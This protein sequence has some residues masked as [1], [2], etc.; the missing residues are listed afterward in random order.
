MEVE[1]Y[2]VL[3]CAIE[4]GSLSAAAE[5]LH[6]TTSGISRMMAALE[7]EIGFPLLLRRHEGVSPTAECLA[8]LP[9]IR[10]FLFHAEACRMQAKRLLGLE[11][12]SVTIGT[13]YGAY[14]G[15]LAEVIASFRKKYPGVVVQLRSGY[16][17]QLARMLEERQLDLCIISRREG[18]FDWYRLFDDELVA[19]LPAEHSEGRN[20]SLPLSVFA[21]EP[22]IEIF[23]GQDSDN[24]R[25]FREY[26]ISPNTRFTTTDSYSACSMVEA[27][28]GITLNNALNSRD[29]GDRIQVLPLEPRQSVEIGLAVARQEAPAVKRFI[30]AVRERLEQAYPQS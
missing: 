11:T 12:G 27:G 26:G 17:S 23:P 30:E 28:L 22:Y 3:V 21:E 20:G 5:K 7:S 4:T 25:L 9:S 16:S 19:W 24:A 13:A 14:Y 15:L 2:Q 6:Y 8:L 10:E 1:R 29:R 18:R